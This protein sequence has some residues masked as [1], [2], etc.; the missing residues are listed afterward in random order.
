MYNFFLQVDAFFY[1]RGLDD[2]I[3]YITYWAGPIEHAIIIL[4]L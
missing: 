4:Y 2:C 1:L 3:N